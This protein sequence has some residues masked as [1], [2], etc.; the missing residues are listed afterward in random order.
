[1][2]VVFLKTIAVRGGA[3]PPFGPFFGMMSESQIPAAVSVAKDLF[4][5]FF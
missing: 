5:I 2:E 3:M 1:L 4:V